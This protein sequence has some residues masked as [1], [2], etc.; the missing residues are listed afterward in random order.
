MLAMEAV[1]WSPVV[2]QNW[3]QQ[4]VLR[5][6]RAWNQ[7]GFG[8]LSSPFL[9]FDHF[10]SQGPIYPPHPHSG[11]SIVTYLAETSPVGFRHRHSF[12]G[13]TEINR[14]DLHWM[15]SGSG[16]VI[17]ETPL[18][19][20]G[21]S[22][23]FQLFVNLKEKNK[24]LMPESFLVK[25]GAAPRLRTPSGALVKICS[26]SY[27]GAEAPFSLPERT[28]IFEV[29]MDAGASF[30]LEL[31]EGCGGMLYCI[32]GSITVD[33]DS[34]FSILEGGASAFRV[35]NTVEVTIRG[36]EAARLLV[37]QGERTD[38]ALIFQGPFAATTIEK[39]SETM[40]RYQ[41]GA[42]GNLDPI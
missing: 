14:G 26:G 39:L 20:D 35:K 11:F 27:L 40:R 13:D 21:V 17:E 42:M 7:F 2:K 4:T 18:D 5:R 16:A 29:S 41:S 31:R 22:E 32:A 30:P 25:N 38:E 6:T 1:H 19:P 24:E 8:G 34:P 33:C 23:G 36:R 37:L 10:Q 28:D 9:H 12:G 15:L 3:Q